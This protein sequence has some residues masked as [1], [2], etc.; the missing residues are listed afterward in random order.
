[1]KI[2]LNTASK[3]G[4]THQR[5]EGRALVWGSELTTKATTLYW[6]GQK[7]WFSALF[8]GLWP[9]FCARI[10]LTWLSGLKRS[11]SGDL[12]VVGLKRRSRR[13]RGR[14]APRG[15]R[16]CHPRPLYKTR[17]RGRGTHLAIA[18][19]HL[20]VRNLARINSL[21]PGSTQEKKAEG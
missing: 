11:P 8:C 5:T 15:T 3:P 1:M 7:N 13:A 6:G 17:R 9:S 4:L 14:R 20:H 19:A 21:W 12:S 10:W 18:L 16:T 2:F